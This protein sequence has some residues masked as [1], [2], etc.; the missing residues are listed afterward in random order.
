MRRRPEHGAVPVVPPPE[1]RGKRESAWASGARRRRLGVAWSPPGPRACARAPGC[2]ARSRTPPHGRLPRERMRGRPQRAARD[3]RLSA[4]AEP[5]ERQGPVRG[6]LPRA[7]S[8]GPARPGRRGA[9]SWGDAAE[10]ARVA[11]CARGACHP[12]TARP[13][14]HHCPHGQIG[15][16]A[17]SPP[18]VSSSRVPDSPARRRQAQAPRRHGGHSRERSP[19]GHVPR[20]PAVAWRRASGA[21]EWWRPASPARC[22]RSAPRRSERP[23]RAPPVRVRSRVRACAGRSRS[24]CPSRPWRAPCPGRPP[25]SSRT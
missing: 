19:V 7:L 15:S 5:P 22:A 13:K 23:A 6:R 8:A 3:E 20:A 14:R 9:V 17:P 21:R 11:A 10:P 4:G 24:L 1:A 12:R 2:A 25:T 16:A 18:A